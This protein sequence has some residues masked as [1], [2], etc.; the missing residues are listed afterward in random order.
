MTRRT[1]SSICLL[2]LP[3]LRPAVVGVATVTADPLGPLLMPFHTTFVRLS[4][5]S[6]V[7]YPPMLIPPQSLPTS[8]ASSTSSFELLELSA[9][10]SVSG[11]SSSACSGKRFGVGRVGGGIARELAGAEAETGFES[12]L[13]GQDERSEGAAAPARERRCRAASLVISAWSPEASE[14]SSDKMRRCDLGF[15]CDSGAA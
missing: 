14:R 6:S 3:G 5:S 8:A 1:S 2:P 4:S 10:R 11:S 15:G 13:G 12:R 7:P 9:R